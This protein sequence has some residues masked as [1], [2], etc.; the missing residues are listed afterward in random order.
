VTG[1]SPWNYLGREI[2]ILNLSI[3]EG[4]IKVEY[5]AQGEGET[6]ETVLKVFAWDGE[7]LTHVYDGAI[8]EGRPFV[9]DDILSVEELSNLTYTL[10]WFDYAL[11]FEEG[12]ASYL[13]FTMDGTATYTYILDTEHIAYGDL[14][15]DEAEDAVVYIGWSVEGF[16]GESAIIAAVYNNHGLPEF[17]DSYVDR[18]GSASRLEELAINEDGTISFNYTDLVHQQL[19]EYAFVLADGELGFE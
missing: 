6:I 12:I 7:S 15:G 1:A 18:Q 19:L 2:V 11:N 3:V 4:E 14:N 5:A 16:E 17:V 13:G 8:V 9:A 10:D